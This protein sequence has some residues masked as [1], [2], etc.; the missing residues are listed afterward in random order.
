MNL[1][2]MRY[3]KCAQPHP[4]QIFSQHQRP[5]GKAKALAIGYATDRPEKHAILIFNSQSQYRRG[6]KETCLS[7]F[8]L[9][10][11]IIF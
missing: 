3:L 5:K 9:F 7:Q 10:F 11:R 2:L 6:G 4:Q 8:L 1:K